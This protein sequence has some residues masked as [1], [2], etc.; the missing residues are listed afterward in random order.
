MPMAQSKKEIRV[1]AVADI[2]VG[3]DS[4]GALQ[5][6][7]AQIATA[8]DILLLGGD[9]TNYGLPEEGHVLIKE[10]GAL[11]IPIVA[12]LGNHD[13]ESGKQEEL[14]NLLLNAGIRV[15]DGEGCEIDGIGIA[16]VKGFCG[17]FGK[18]MLPSWGEDSVKEWVKEALAESLKLESALARLR[19][20]RRIAVLHYAPTQATVE[21]EPL[22]IFPFLGCSR[23]EEPLNRYAVTAAFHGHAHHG[24]PHGRTGTG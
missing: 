23:L 17:G 10:L 18:F 6:L 20:A 19:P 16:G 12:V 7:C 13:F 4:Q 9:L 14:R 3:K 5:P 21:G 2:H 22:E 15:L 8:A 1:A 24:Q 11:K